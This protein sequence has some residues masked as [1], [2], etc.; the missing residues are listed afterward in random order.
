MLCCSWDVA[1]DECNC[2]FSFWTIFFPFCPPNSLKNE[3]F[4]KKKVI[5]TPGDIILHKCTKNHDHMQYY[6]WDMGSEGCNCYFSFW[7]AFCPFTRCFLPFYK[8]CYAYTKICEQ[9]WFLCIKII[10]ICQTP[11]DHNCLRK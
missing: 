4:N 3:N 5:K 10:W 8:R 11:T 6:S 1:H 9:Y 2:Y 7:A